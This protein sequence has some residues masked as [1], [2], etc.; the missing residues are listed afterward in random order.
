MPGILGLIS[1]RPPLD[2]Q[3]LIGKMLHSMEH[4]KFYRS[5]TECAP[6]LGIYAGWVAIEGSFSER[7]SA[8]PIDG[9]TVLISGE[10]ALP[11]S[12]DASALAMADYGWL[13]KS[14]REIGGA[15][16]SQ[17]NGVFSGLLIDRKL[18]RAFLF[19]DRF[20][21]ERIYYRQVGEDLYFASEAKAL[22]RVLA[23]SR[24]FDEDGIAQYLTFGC[25]AGWKTLFRHLKL[26][27][28]GSI[29]ALLKNNSPEYYF[30]PAEW[31]SQPPLTEAGFQNEFNEKFR[32]LLPSYFEADRA[33][34][35]SLTGGLDTRMIMAGRPSKAEIALCYTFVGVKGRPLDAVLAAQIA[36]LSGIPYRTLPISTDFFENFHRLAD[37][38]VWIT[39][40]Y[41][42]VTGAHEIYFNGLARQLAP[43]RITG[44]FGSEVLRG[45]S[46]FKPMRLSSDLLDPAFRQS[47]ALQGE[48]VPSSSTHPVTAAAFREI[49]W[50]LFGSLSAGRSQVTFRT[51]YLDNE[52]VAL[53]YRI[54]AALRRSPQSALGFIRTASPGLSK[55]ATDR[56]LKDGSNRA[57]RLAARA[58]AEFTF[59]LDYYY[60]EG[61]PNWLTPADPILASLQWFGLLGLHKYL[62]YRRWF[63]REL[64]GYMHEKVALASQSAIW[65]Q[66]FLS[67]M[68]SDH[69]SGRKNYVKEINAVLTLEAIERLLFRQN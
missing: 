68:L 1:Q 19:N 6:E 53:A 32:N 2:C 21:L 42:G 5:G 63:R 31:E 30:T 27:P 54:P 13:V 10:C 24:E 50:G 44:N 69:I 11:D 25:T 4:E 28:G 65:N 7:N 34:G 17:L 61:L 20:G 3:E 46:T 62:L 47:V 58:F 40:G 37:K 16:V 15:F 26:L 29:W 8:A 39:D 33:I 52:L 67:R 38:T 59:K 18:K 57:S 12:A 55:M 49:P 35:I 48:Q 60:S 45:M 64:R 23:D 9:V 36:S 66:D 41:F 14:Y 51:P 43:I 22:L 56:G